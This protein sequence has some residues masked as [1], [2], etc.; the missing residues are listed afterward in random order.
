MPSSR[1]RS[2]LSATERTAMPA[3]VRRRNQPRATSTTGT[4][5]AMRR[6][7]PLKSTGKIRTWCALSGV[8]T[9]P[10]MEGPF[11]QPGHEQLDPA[12][13]LGQA[14][15]DDHDD[16]PRCGE[17]APADDE[18]DEQAQ[19]RPDQQGDPDADE[20]VDVVGQV[21]LDG[22]R[23]RQRAHG[24]VGEV[25]D[26]RGAVGEHEAQGQQPVD[27]AELRPVEDLPA[28]RRSA[29]RGPGRRRAGSRAAATRQHGAAQAR[30]RGRPGAADGAGVTVPPSGRASPRRPTA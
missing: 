17:E 28:R 15:G 22:D 21:Q 12:E 2:E 3:S 24:A 13:E 8:V 10:T 11:S 16:Q 1:A 4:T 18:V 7:F 19:R 30:R 23:G 29:A 20:P 27:R 26:P 25:D 14:D 6:S 9:P 5:M